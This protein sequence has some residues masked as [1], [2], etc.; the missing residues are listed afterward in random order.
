MFAASARRNWL[1]P[2]C[3]TEPLPRPAQAPHAGRAQGRAALLS[4]A[5]IPR[6]RAPTTDHRLAPMCVE[7][8]RGMTGRS[9]P[10]HSAIPPGKTGHS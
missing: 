7:L 1:L 10:F 2:A 5:A 4:F 3:F 6:L 9:D 8:E